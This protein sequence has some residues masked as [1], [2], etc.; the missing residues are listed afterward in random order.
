M[1]KKPGRP[2]GSVVRW[3]PEWDRDIWARVEAIRDHTG[4]D[5][6]AA[7]RRLSYAGYIQFFVRLS[8][9]VD[10]EKPHDGKAWVTR[11]PAAGDPAWVHTIFDK[12]DSGALRRGDAR[13]E[14]PEQTFRQRYYAA[15]RRM[16]RD[17]TYREEC[18]FWKRVYLRALRGEDPV[19]AFL[20]EP[21]PT[22]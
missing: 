12:I 17:P 5:R 16:R 7:C 20:D 19:Q 3:K 8:R 18:L 15:A 6:V 21:Q 22:R 11:P 13:N 9:T 2:P 4:L 14:G 10:P 1:K